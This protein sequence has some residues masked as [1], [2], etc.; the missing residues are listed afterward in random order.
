MMFVMM[1][2]MMIIT[3]MIA[4]IVRL[5]TPQNQSPNYASKNASL[6]DSEDSICILSNDTV[7]HLDEARYQSLESTH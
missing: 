3:V 1:M 5:M 2:M 6:L 7:A 4:M